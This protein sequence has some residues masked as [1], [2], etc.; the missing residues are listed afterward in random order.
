MLVAAGTRG[1]GKSRSRGGETVQS[2]VHVQY[3]SELA[4]GS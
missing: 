4:R 3:V 2:R 1:V